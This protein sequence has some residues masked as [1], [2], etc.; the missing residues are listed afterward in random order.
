MYGG[1]V[2]RVH[3]LLLCGVDPSMVDLRTCMDHLQS[4]EG[5]SFVYRDTESLLKAASRPWVPSHHAY[6]YGPE[7]RACIAS[8]CLVKVHIFD[9]LTFCVYSRLVLRFILSSHL[10]FTLFSFRPT[11]ITLGAL[12]V[13]ALCH[14]SPLRCG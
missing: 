13:L 8:V 11:C 6:L 5:D 7:F 10:F 1:L 4:G 9:C 2:D 14:I 12:V 3:D